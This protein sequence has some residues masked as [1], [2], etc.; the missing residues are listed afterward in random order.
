MP[1]IPQPAGE[2]GSLKWIQHFIEY[3]PQRLE[4]EGIK[5]IAWLSPLRS[6]EF[7]E[8][9]DT[10]WLQKVDLN[11]LSDKL[12]TFWPSK[13]PQWDALGKSEGKIILVE[14]KAH[15]REFFSPGTMASQNSKMKIDDSLDW[16]KSALNAKDISDWSQVFY[17]YTNRLAHL[18]WLRE[19][20][21]DAHL[22]FVSFIGDVEMNGPKRAQ[23]WQ[24][25]FQTAEHALGLLPKHKLSP[26]IHH[27]CPDVTNLG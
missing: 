18:Y 19:Q 8:Y 14:A 13:G 1:R 15:I 25:A 26:Y 27:I 10:A 20:G 12:K 17:Q 21:V 5:T 4:P 6:D 16:V 23:E 22:L 7:S 24:V 2:K 9:R 3:Y 11:N